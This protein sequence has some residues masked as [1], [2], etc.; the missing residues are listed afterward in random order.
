MKRLCPLMISFIAV[1]GLLSCSGAPKQEKNGR[2]T[3]VYSGNIGARYDPCGCRIPL[4]GF[5]RRST[6]IDSI[7]TADSDILVLDTGA[8]IFERH[9]LYP[10]YE[11]VNR[12]TAH[13]VVEVM[14]KLGMDAANVSAMDLSDG[15]DSL[16]AYAAASS[17]PWLSANVVR[18]GT[19]EL[20]FTPDILKTVG[21]LNVGV[22]GFMDRVTMGIPFF[23]ERSPVDVLDPIET[24]R[25]EVA[26]LRSRGAD[27]I[28]ALAYMD[29]ENV[30]LLINA[31]PGINLLI[32]GHTKEH[33]PSSDQTF[34]VPYMIGETIVARCPD[35]GRVIGAMKLEMWHGSTHFEDGSAAA[36]LRPEAVRQAEDSKDKRS[37]YTH[38]FIELSPA[39]KRDRAVQDRLDEV[40]KRIESLRDSLRTEAEKK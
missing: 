19:G 8:L 32:Y 35:G 11:P 9:H 36:R 21:G 12:M 39:I 3:I 2:V 31:V 14:N 13:L 29:K 38:S 26:K 10:P 1:I 7:R 5:A 18:R 27:L 23:D 40:G 25:S 37:N 16:L 30:E 34:F 22:F 17:W 33:N 24:A 4:G 15:P 6:A 20:L 28:V